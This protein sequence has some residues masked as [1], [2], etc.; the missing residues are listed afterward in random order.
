MSQVAA[1]MPTYLRGPGPY[2]PANTPWSSYVS[3]IKTHLDQAKVTD[4]AEKRYFLLQQ[5]GAKAYHQL[6]VALNGQEVTSKSFRDLCTILADLYDPPAMVAPIRHKIFSLRQKAGQSTDDFVMEIMALSMKA[7]LDNITNTR[8]FVQVQAIIAGIRDDKTRARLLEEESPSLDRI[9][10]LIRTSEQSRSAALAMKAEAESV[11]AQ[12][13]RRRPVK[14]P[15]FPRGQVRPEQ[16]Q[17][18]YKCGSQ[19]HLI[20]NCPKMK[21][22]YHPPQRGKQRSYRNVRQ[23]HVDDQGEDYDG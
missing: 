1:A 12:V 5:I 6:I 15:R 8:E 10:T 18:C 4:D 20:R 21:G 11:V 9:R 23:V 7:Q 13:D 2:D 14:N 19:E 22:R 16:T 17:R 3:L